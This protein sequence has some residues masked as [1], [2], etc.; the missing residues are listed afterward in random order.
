MSD[1]I[2]QARRLIEA[3][4][5]ARDSLRAINADGELRDWA[6]FGGVSQLLATID[7]QAAEIASLEDLVSHCWA[8]RDYCDCGYEQMTTEQRQLHDAAITHSNK[9]AGI[10]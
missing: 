8:H 6:A 1:H 10:E 9:R 3:K 7:A 4:S 2:E 5:A